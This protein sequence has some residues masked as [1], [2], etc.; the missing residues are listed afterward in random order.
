[1]PAEE[2]M[3]RWLLRHH[4]SAVSELVRRQQV[5]HFQFEEVDQEE[6]YQELASFHEVGMEQFQV[7]EAVAQLK[8]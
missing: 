6:K 2:W 3:E 5:A 4:S 1:M 8:I 7:I